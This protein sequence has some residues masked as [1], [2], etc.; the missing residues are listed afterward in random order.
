MPKLGAKELGEVTGRLRSPRITHNAEAVTSIQQYVEKL[1]EGVKYDP[2]STYQSLLSCDEWVGKHGTR[3]NGLRC[4]EWPNISLLGMQEKEQQLKSALKLY[5][6]RLEWLD[7]STRRYFGVLRGRKIAFLIDVTFADFSS[8]RSRLETLIDDDS[9]KSKD[10]VMLMAFGADPQKIETHRVESLTPDS[11]EFIFNW[12]QRIGRGSDIGSGSTQPP[13]PSSS[14]NGSSE[15][16][17]ENAA[18]PHVI[19]AVKVALRSGG[20]DCIYVLVGHRP[21]HSLMSSV[22]R[23]EELCAENRA[24]IHVINYAAQDII[25]SVYLKKLAEV[26]HGQLH[27]FDGTDSLCERMP[28]GVAGD[29]VEAVR[30]EIGVVREGLD[31]VLKRKRF[32]ESRMEAIGHADH[33]ISIP[34]SANEGTMPKTKS[35]VPL[36][37]DRSNRTQKLREEKLL[38]VKCGR[39]NGASTSEINRLRLSQANAKRG[40]YFDPPDACL[41]SEGWLQI[42]GIKAR[43]M[44]IYHE[45]SDIAYTCSKP[46]QYIGRAYKTLTVVPWK[47]GTTKAVH[48]DLERMAEYRK[49]LVKQFKLYNDRLKWLG[50]GTRR[51]FGNVVGEVV[52]ILIDTTARMKESMEGMKL[53]LRSLFTEQLIYRKWFN[54][55]RFDTTAEKWR[56]N[57]AEVTEKNLT[58]ALAWIDT[59][60]CASHNSRDIYG[61]ITL[62]CDALQPQNHGRHEIYLLASGAADQK[63]RELYEF[64]RETMADG[65]TTIHTIAYNCYHERAAGEVLAKLARIT[66]GRFHICVEEGTV[67]DELHE[68]DISWTIDPH[69]FSIKMSDTRDETL[70]E[71]TNSGNMVDPGMQAYD[72]IV[73]FLELKSKESR[74]ERPK[75]CLCDG[76]DAAILRKELRRGK[77]SIDKLDDILTALPP[78]YANVAELIS[79]GGS[80][81]PEMMKSLKAARS[82]TVRKKKATEAKAKQAAPRKPPPR[83]APPKVEASEPV[84]SS[85]AA[86]LIRAK[87]GI[88]SRQGRF[89]ISNSSPA[90]HPQPTM[91]VDKELKPGPQPRSP[92][93]YRPPARLPKTEELMSSKAWIKSFGLHAL[94]L[95]ILQ[96]MK[97]NGAQ[98]KKINPVVSKHMSDTHLD[99]GPAK[100]AEYIKN[101]TAAITRYEARLQWL[102]TDTRRMF[103]QIIEKNIVVAIDTSGSMTEGFA[104][105]QAQLAALLN[106]QILDHCHR[107]NVVRFSDADRVAS[108]TNPV[109]GGTAGRYSC[110]ID[111]NEDTCAGAAAWVRTLDCFGGTDVI[112]AMRVAL[113]DVTTEA[114]Y[115]IS[116]GKPD[117]SSDEALRQ[118]RALTA[119]RNVKVH[120]V[121][122]LSSVEAG[123]GSGAAEFLKR[124][125]DQHGGRYHEYIREPRES[126][127][128]FVFNRT[129]E[130]MIEEIA[131]GNEHSS[132]SGDD[133][134]MI[135]TEIKFARDCLFRA[136]SNL[137]NAESRREELIS[138][139][140]PKKASTRIAWGEGINSRKRDAVGSQTTPSVP[141]PKP[142]ATRTSTLLAETGSQKRIML[143]GLRS[144][145]IT[146][147]SQGTDS[148][149]EELSDSE[150]SMT[151]NMASSSAQH[152]R[153]PA[154]SKTGL[155]GT[156][157]MIKSTS[158]QPSSAVRQPQ[159]YAKWYPKNRAFITNLP[160]QGVIPAAL[161]KVIFANSGIRV[162]PKSIEV[163]WDDDRNEQRGFAYVSF[164]S[165][166]DLLR[167]MKLNGTVFMGHNLVINVASDP[168]ADKRLLNDLASGLKGMKMV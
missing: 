3:A 101:I 136:T 76:D 91:R 88:G 68:N 11:L 165:K 22:P 2:A 60:E 48:I 98:V 10:A 36:R 106:T 118:A 149:S 75:V 144:L 44:T 78:G 100:W 8:L 148:S 61:A 85:I 138:T 139:R 72:A 113:E 65:G 84:R 74:R 26:G 99:L 30:T 87:T 34:A 69:E 16:V 73:K 49:R 126:D 137:T 4:G 81:D 93:P 57:I 58:D 63:P 92:K 161:S 162:S 95:D 14:I 105:V 114:I 55:V 128:I 45:L 21:R 32:L 109:P 28:D 120:T 122:W 159:S 119:G 123:H 54:V 9:F 80:P 89:M 56:F 158:L 79:R 141:L 40:N 110:L 94:Q 1:E 129:R 111:V 115:L 168:S 130:Q 97:L 86:K 42:H 43:K 46:G 125:A 142:K 82:A 140:P 96:F 135:S 132:C 51:I 7:S 70:D 39:T 25:T 27:V 50:T 23:F 131:D 117:C 67:L 107:F 71:D 66:S 102:Q 77:H 146:A 35:G 147:E 151:N 83:P 155:L 103:G 152:S 133:I 134:A 33:P 31:F 18:G 150:N 38:G 143:T 112:G 47:D 90:G 41:T 17:E 153:I 167:A 108:W 154:F 64:A 157:E 37:M 12:L 15:L 13:K 52:T 163:P 145:S 166:T 156:P 127:T 6:M 160:R 53:H 164:T 5:E 104:Y 62:A 20:I 19:Q 121:A 116:D 24:P 124:L 59:W 29:D